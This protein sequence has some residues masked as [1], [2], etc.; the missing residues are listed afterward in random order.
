[1]PFQCRGR[2]RR[3]LRV[4]MGPLV[5]PIC[6]MFT[7]TAA[8][9]CE[10][11]PAAGRRNYFTL[12]RRT[13]GG[14]RYAL[15][16]R[17]IVRRERLRLPALC[18]APARR[19]PS[20]WAARRPSASGPTATRGTSSCRP[21]A[22]CPRTPVRAPPG[23]HGRKISWSQPGG[24]MRRATSPHWRVCWRMRAPTFRRRR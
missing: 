20:R 19:W 5:V 18:R 22:T 16:A 8:A 4:G 6:G 1:M 24:P 17:S 11:C 15:R 21:T 7:A 10:T 3:R 9:W 13:A 2:R 23:G 12:R 14:G